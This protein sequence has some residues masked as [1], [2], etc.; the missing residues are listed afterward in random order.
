M[1]TNLEIKEQKEVNDIV[2]GI[3]KRQ[4]WNY[5]ADLGKRI[6]EEYQIARI[7]MDKKLADKCV[8][9]RQELE[10]WLMDNIDEDSVVEYYNAL[11]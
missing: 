5:Y 9:A 4:S 8:K 10:L 7:K 2:N 6:I 1:N 3:T 11:N